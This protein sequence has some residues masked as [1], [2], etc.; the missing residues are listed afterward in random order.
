MSTSRH[1]GASLHRPRP[2]SCP[3]R[4]ASLLAAWLPAYRGSRA[5]F[6]PRPP[7]FAPPFPAT[8]PTLRCFCPSSN[9]KNPHRHGASI[10]RFSPTA[11]IRRGSVPCGTLTFGARQIKSYPF[12]APVSCREDA[13]LLFVGLCREA[14]P[15]Y[16]KKIGA[17][18]GACRTCAYEARGLCPSTSGLRNRYP[19]EWL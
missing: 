19:R 3:Q 10:Q 12:D 9:L 6:H 7:P 2:R 17:E 13:R 1:G 15:E 4:R 16:S 8:A 11:F 14:Q 5:P 18:T